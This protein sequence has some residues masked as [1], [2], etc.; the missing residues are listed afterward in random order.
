MKREIDTT[1]EFVVFTT[2]PDPDLVPLKVHEIE[3]GS[4]PSMQEAEAF[5]RKLFTTE[6]VPDV[7]ISERKWA[8][9]TIPK[10]W[11]AAHHHRAELR[12]D[13]MNQAK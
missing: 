9:L 2:N 4:F 10:R 13:R 12:T 11:Y 6:G 3:R 8:H 1:P 5:S 7:Q